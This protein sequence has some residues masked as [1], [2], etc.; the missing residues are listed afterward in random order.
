MLDSVII[1]YFLY[2]RST[3]GKNRSKYEVR[4]N[5]IKMISFDLTC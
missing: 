4:L 5:L 3:F 1:V 2:F